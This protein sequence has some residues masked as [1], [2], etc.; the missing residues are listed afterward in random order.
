MRG[1]YVK[2]EICSLIRDGKLQPGDKVERRCVK[3]SKAFMGHVYFN[4]TVKYLVII[5][6]RCNKCRRDERAGA[7][8]H[9]GVTKGV[10]RVGDCKPTDL[11][12]QMVPPVGLSV[13]APTEVSHVMEYLA[14]AWR[15]MSEDSRELLVQKIEM[16]VGLNRRKVQP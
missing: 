15:L 13:P 14:Y 7:K 4:K 2:G 5:P 12:V 11:P 1:P 16:F 6:S 8:E 9:A 3:C 10:S